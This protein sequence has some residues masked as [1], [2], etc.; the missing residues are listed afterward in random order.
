MQVRS[1]N[2]GAFA[3]ASSLAGLIMLNLALSTYFLVQGDGEY[4]YNIGGRCGGGTLGDAWFAQG[5]RRH[6]GDSPLP[7]TGRT[8]V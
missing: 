4:N 2:V 3:F 1:Y 7:R 8:R 6:D 5:H